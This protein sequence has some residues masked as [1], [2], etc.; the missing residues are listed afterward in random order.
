MGACI[1]YTKEFHRVSWPP[2]FRS[3]LPARYDD[4]GDP[5]EFLQLFIVSIE[6]AGG[7]QKVLANW[8]PMALKDTARS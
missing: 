5:T 4:H 6:A 2:K 8:F 1:A 3:D 7:D